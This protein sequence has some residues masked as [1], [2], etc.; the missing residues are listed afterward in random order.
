[1]KTHYSKAFSG[2]GFDDKIIVEEVSGAKEIRYE[3][4]RILGRGTFSKVYQCVQVDTKTTYA[5]KVVSKSFLLKF[6][7]R[8]QFTKEIKIH[9]MMEHQNII[10]LVKVFENRAFIFMV[11]EFSENGT[12]ADLIERRKTLSEVEMRY[13][14]RWLIEGVQYIHDKGVVHRDLKPANLIISNNMEL[15]IADF[16]LAN[17]IVPGKKR[18]TLCGTPFFIAPEILNKK[19]GHSFEVDWWSTGVILYNMAYGRYPFL[20]DTPDAVYKKIKDD[21]IVTTEQC[22]AELNDLVRKLLVKSLDERANYDGC[23]AHPFLNKL[24]NPQ[25]LP[26]HF[27]E[28]APSES[29]IVKYESHLDEAES[30]KEQNPNE[31]V[32]YSKMSKSFGY[33][34]QSESLKDVGFN[35]YQ[36]VKKWV[37]FSEKFGIGYILNNG[38][39]GIYFTDRTKIVLSNFGI[40]FHYIFSKDAK[41]VVEMHNIIN[42]PTELE[43][44]VK[45][46]EFFIT[47]LKANGHM[48]RNAVA[49]PDEFVYVKNYKITKYAVIFLLS[50][51][52][53]QAIFE[54]GSEVHINKLDEARRIVFI[55][56]ARNRTFSDGKN[57]SDETL[58]TRIKYIKDTLKSLNA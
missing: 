19:E 53:Y 8:E 26:A 45:I 56:K 12:I 28:T 11:L 4:V 16:G 37:N 33:E 47:H 54:D 34:E 31:E 44:K 21:D 50:N 14:F 9:F 18:K 3:K 6:N 20:G 13:Y 25:C 30:E 43:K 38:T 1:M 32:V 2:L 48:Q 49:S 17:Y 52:V 39:I 10:K 42:Y 57:I 58:V 55:D 41:S 35:E 22:S 27:L 51:G 7:L 29:F 24:K 23:V 15:K 36:Y 46:L 5:I 40:T